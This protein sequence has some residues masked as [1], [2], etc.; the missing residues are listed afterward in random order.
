MSENSKKIELPSTN[1]NLSKTRLLN[2]LKPLCI[3]IP[4]M[5]D[6]IK[7]LKDI[8]LPESPFEYF[9]LC[10]KIVLEMH[11]VTDIYS[12]P[13]ANE[14]RDFIKNCAED[15]KVKRSKETFEKVL[16]KVAKEMKSKNYKNT[17]GSP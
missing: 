2:T 11:K 5:Q 16:E 7:Y 3:D 17:S 6:T 10:E 4:W 12:N 15:I 9:G 14:L 1:G 13:R 8:D